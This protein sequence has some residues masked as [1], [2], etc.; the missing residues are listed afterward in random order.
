MWKLVLAG[1]R[2]CGFTGVALPGERCCPD[3][4]S[5]R[6]ASPEKRPGCWLSIG[7]TDRQTDKVGPM[8][9]LSDYCALKCE[10]VF[11]F[12]LLMSQCPS[13]PQNPSK[14]KHFGEE[15]SE[16]RTNEGKNGS[17]Q[18]K[19]VVVFC[20]FSGLPVRVWVLLQRLS[21]GHRGGVIKQISHRL[22][23]ACAAAG[24]HGDKGNVIW[25][26]WLRGC[27]DARCLSDTAEQRQNKGTEI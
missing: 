8:D 22:I 9:T 24:F 5:Y 4:M 23:V 26:P 6:W 18:T 13:E 14:T 12:N 17:R 3:F 7:K 20:F 19:I 16:E 1:T 15:W 21:G 2:L 11:R 27:R 25:S 10:N